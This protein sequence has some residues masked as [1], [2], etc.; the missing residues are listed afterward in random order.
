MVHSA[1]TIPDI[2]PDIRY[3]ELK[4][5]YRPNLFNMGHFMFDDS[6]GRDSRIQNERIQRDIHFKYLGNIR[7]VYVFYF[8]AVSCV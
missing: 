3:I 8:Q 5:P 4:K 2:I 1:K 7:I 6:L